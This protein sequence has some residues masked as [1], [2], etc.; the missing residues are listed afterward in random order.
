MASSPLLSKFS[1]F[2]SSTFGSL[3]LSEEFVS[4]VRVVAEKY[5]NRAAHPDIVDLP[6]AQE[7]QQLIRRILPRLLESYPDQ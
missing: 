3:P 4:E 2:V 7:C 5:R 6:T 1:Q